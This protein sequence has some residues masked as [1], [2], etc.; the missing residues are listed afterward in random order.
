M[1]N[2]AAD[3]ERALVGIHYFGG[4]WESTPNKWHEPADGHDWRP[5][6]PERMP[7]LGQYNSQAVMDLEIEAAAAHGVDFFSILWYPEVNGEPDPPLLNRVVDYFIKS[8][9]AARMKFI[10]EFCNHPPFF[11]KTEAEWSACLDVF[12]KAMRSPSYL[13]VG[14]RLVFKV[15][16]SEQFY[17]D[18][19][20]DVGRCRARLDL[21]RERVREAG[22]GE[23]VITGGA[24]GVVQAGGWQA[25]LFDF[26]SEY[27]VPAPIPQAEHAFP[28]VEQ[29]K[30]DRVVRR[31][32]E[33]S[34][35]PYMPFLSAGWNP[36]PWGDPRASFAFP[37]REEWGLALRNT[38]QDLAQSKKLGIPLPGGGVQKAFTIYAWNEF[39]EG[40]IV[41]P[42]QGEGAMKLEGIRDVFG[43]RR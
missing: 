20:R 32:M 1:T 5:E 18:N 14:G 37:T 25:E 17:A 21:L 10:V 7:L 6:Y 24:T 41:A 43:V 12:V 27:M 42:N 22:L 23:L 15:H 38:A 3:Q 30:H 13:R 33:G 39:G 29:A 35:L 4:W 8:P 9:N 19:D 11:V 2:H 34:V 28:Y 40:G 16:S 31:E 26:S 36:K